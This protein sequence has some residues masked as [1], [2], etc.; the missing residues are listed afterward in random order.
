MTTVHEDPVI[1]AYRRRAVR[2]EKRA[3]KAERQRDALYALVSKSY[4]N[5]YSAGLERAKVGGRKPSSPRGRRP[6]HERVMAS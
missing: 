3:E 6:L 2:A 4:R 5:G 1:E